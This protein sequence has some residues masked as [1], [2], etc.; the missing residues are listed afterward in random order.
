MIIVN[1]PPNKSFSSPLE[2]KMQYPSNWKVEGFRDSLRLFSSKED[3][4]DKYIQTINLFTYPN[5][6]LNQAVESLTNY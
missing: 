2:I 3:T 1:L 4:N 6:S 5:M